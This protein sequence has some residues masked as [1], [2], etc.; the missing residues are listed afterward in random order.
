MATI[1]DVAK[2]AGVSISTVSLAFNS[3]ERVSEVT[4]EKIFSAVRSLN[5]VPMKEHKRAALDKHKNESIAVIIHQLV[6]PY[7]FEVLRG[8]C[9]TIYRNKKEMVLYSGDEA[10]ER[11]FLNIVRNRV[12]QGV[13]LVNATIQDKYLQEAV[14]SGFPVVM[15]C[16]R[17]GYRGISSVR[18][19]NEEIGRMVAAHFIKR[20]F[21]KI[22]LV[23]RIHDEI[24]FRRG[25]FL[26]TLEKNGIIVPEEWELPCEL[27]GDAAY[28][29]VNSFLK[30][31]Q[32]YPEAFFCLNDDS[33]I[34]TIEAIRNNGLSVPDDISIVGCD[35]LNRSKYNIPSLTT[36]STPK[37]E[38]GMLAV[39]ML[40]RRIAGFPPEEIVLDGKMILRESCL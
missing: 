21:R 3:P 36:V 16:Y 4:R 37:I 26:R 7:F 1:K 14:E 11:Y 23:G 30:S 8:I 25:C 33:A 27:T 35:D 17:T 9:E 29:T 38:F 22:G 20:K 40:I 12:Y 5:Y 2:L 34:G 32:D 28:K 39:N 13:I 15:C 24:T 10:V 19:N 18:I 31:G 6:G